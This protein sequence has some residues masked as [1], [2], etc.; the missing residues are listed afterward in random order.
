VVKTIPADLQTSGFEIIKE[1]GTGILKYKGRIQ[2]YQ[3]TYIEGG[4]FAGKRILR[5]Q[6]RQL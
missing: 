5:T 4:L 1:E 6:D 2:G 3:P